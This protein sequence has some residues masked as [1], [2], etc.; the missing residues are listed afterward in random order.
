MLDMSALSNAEAE[1][2][3]S[4]R[5]DVMKRSTDREEKYEGEPLMSLKL[6]PSDP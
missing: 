5:C 2:L 3:A 4:T 6:D 1:R